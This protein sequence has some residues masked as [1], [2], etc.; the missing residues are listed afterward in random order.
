V[1]RVNVMI[2]RVL[3]MSAGLLLVASTGCST[4]TLTAEERFQRIGRNIGLEWQMMQD[5][6]DSALLLRPVTQLSQ[7]KI[8]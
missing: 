8:R 7:W 6:I 3:L 4:P 2:K 1:Q 5:D